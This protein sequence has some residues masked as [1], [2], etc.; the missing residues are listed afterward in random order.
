M[1]RRSE[2]DMNGPTRDQITGS[3][4]K[5]GK[6]LIKWSDKASVTVAWIFFP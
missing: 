6:A 3:L 4:E 5:A 1:N 2:E